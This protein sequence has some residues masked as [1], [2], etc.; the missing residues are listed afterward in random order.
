MSYD[1]GF[2][3]EPYNEDVNWENVTNYFNGCGR[4]NIHLHDLFACLGTRHLV[5]A[6]EF[7][8]YYE[9][10]IEVKKLAFIE[11]LYKQVT[12][13]KYYNIILKLCRFNDNFVE[14]Y[15]DNM[16]IQDKAE[17]RLAFLL[18]NADYVIGDICLELYD[19]FEEGYDMIS[20][21][22]EAYQKMIA[23]GTKTVWLYGD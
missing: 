20:A 6:D 15:V 2:N 11:E 12:A 18:D 7:S 16:S 14:D 9:Y 22:Y 21:F 4:D 19:K 1:Y 8:E 13:N 10:E 23:D 5:V 17:L 3:R